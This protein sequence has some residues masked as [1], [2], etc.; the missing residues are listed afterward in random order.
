M[1]PKKCSVKLQ[2]GDIV[3]AAAYSWGVQFARLRGDRGGRSEGK[4]ETPELA[5]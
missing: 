1:A 4:R 2:P 3:S 5:M